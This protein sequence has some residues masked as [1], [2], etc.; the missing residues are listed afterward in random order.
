MK[1]E[2]LK[3]IRK[4]NQVIAGSKE[5][6][7]KCSIKEI[8]ADKQNWAKSILRYVNSDVFDKYDATG[9]LNKAPAA[10]WSENI[11]HSEPENIEEFRKVIHNVYGNRRAER[12]LLADASTMKELLDE[13]KA[14]EE[15]EDLIKKLQLSWLTS[16]L[17]KVYQRAVK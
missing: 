8:L 6:Q 16:E 12:Q 10:V 4:I 1:E 5:A 11:F 7:D 3:I 17:E 14:W 13:L 15:K 9:F 2:S